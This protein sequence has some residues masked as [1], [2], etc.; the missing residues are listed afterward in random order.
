[1]PEIA[2][3]FIHDRPTF[4]AQARLHTQRHAVR[5]ASE[6][7]IWDHNRWSWVDAGF[8]ADVEVYKRPKPKI[9]KENDAKRSNASKSEASLGNIPKRYNLSVLQWLQV[10]LMFLPFCILTIAYQVRVGQLDPPL[11]WMFL[12]RYDNLIIVT[13]L[14]VLVIV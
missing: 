14:L 6:Y 11:S 9:Q 5:Q 7:P 8:N 1:M 10:F 13:S 4:D 2:E 12:D 3:Q